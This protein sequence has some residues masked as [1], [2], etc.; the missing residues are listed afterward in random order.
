ML[1]TPGLRTP[2]QNREVTALILFTVLL[3]AALMSVF[4]V[5]RPSDRVDGAQSAAGQTRVM[6]GMGLIMPENVRVP[7][8]ARLFD[9]AIGD[10][11]FKAGQARL[12]AGAYTFKAHNYGVVAHD[13]MIERAPIKLSAPGTPIDEA[14]PFGLDGMQPGMTKS[15]KI[16]LTA[17]K[18]ELFCSVPGHYQSGQHQTITVYGRMPRGMRP[19]K[20]GGMNSVSGMGG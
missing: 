15:A 7:V 2:L 16:M 12:H 5:T 19:P 9:V 4:V 8:G 10:Y 11:W 14:A 17:G 6:P 3:I 1:G 20:S 18:W 13:I